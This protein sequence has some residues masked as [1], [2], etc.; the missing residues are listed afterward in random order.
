VL[1]NFQKPKETAILAPRVVVIDLPYKKTPK[2]KNTS[3]KAQIVNM[4]EIKEEDEN[5]EDFQ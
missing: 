2:R 4:T 5:E 3:S 1:R